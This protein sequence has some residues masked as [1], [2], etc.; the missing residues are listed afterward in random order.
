M[1]LNE[2][3]ILVVGCID[4]MYSYISK[5]VHVRLGHVK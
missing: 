2:H 5:E 4:P 3:I 1:M